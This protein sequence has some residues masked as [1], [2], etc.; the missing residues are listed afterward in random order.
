MGRKFPF[1]EVRLDLGDFNELGIK[2]VFQSLKN[3][4]VTCRPGIYESKRREELLASALRSGARF[5]DIEVETPSSSLKQLSSLAKKKKA[6]VI[7][8]FHD[9]K[10]TPSTRTLNSIIQKAKR[11][12]ADIVKIATLVNSEKDAKV[13][14]SLL[15][16]HKSL[17]VIAMGDRGRSLRIAAPLL[18]SLFAFAAPEPGKETAPGQIDFKTLSELYKSL[19]LTKA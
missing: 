11:R 10:G 13:L 18:G 9:F 17:V 7:V 5:I 4:V 16:K 8:S 3:A 19:G 12:G 6:R 15:A 2:R 1:V 14:L